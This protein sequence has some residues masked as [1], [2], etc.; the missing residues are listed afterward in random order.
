MEEA[1]RRLRDIEAG[2]VSTM[3]W[4]EARER[5]VAREP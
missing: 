4:S 3:P 1:R 2:R 5:I